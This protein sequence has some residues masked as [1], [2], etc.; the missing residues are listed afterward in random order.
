MGD[1]IKAQHA[2]GIITDETLRKWMEGQ[3]YVAGLKLLIGIAV[4][5]LFKG[6]FLLWILFFILYVVKVKE[7]KKQAWAK[8]MEQCKYYYE[9]D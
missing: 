7:I 4:T 1:H 9:E 3:I 5:A 6:Q 2:K 8:E